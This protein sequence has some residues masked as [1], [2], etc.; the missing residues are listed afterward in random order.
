MCNALQLPYRTKHIAGGPYSVNYLLMQSYMQVTQQQ[1]KSDWLT[2]WFSVSEKNNHGMYNQHMYR[3][4]IPG[5]LCVLGPLD[6]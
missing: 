6:K 3:G 4:R 2:F 1:N 5:I